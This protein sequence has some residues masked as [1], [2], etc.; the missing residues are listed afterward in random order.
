MSK[1][2]GYYENF[3]IYII[4]LHFFAIRYW[5]PFKQLFEHPKKLHFKPHRNIHWWDFNYHKQT[6]TNLF[7]IQ[8]LV[9]TQHETHSKFSIARYF[10]PQHLTNNT[11]HCQAHPIIRSAYFFLL[12]IKNEIMLHEI[13]IQSQIFIHECCNDSVYC[14]C[15]SWGLSKAWLPKAFY[16]SSLENDL[17][18]SRFCYARYFH[19]NSPRW[20]LFQKLSH[21]CM[22]FFTLFPLSI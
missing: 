1:K 13:W 12:Q 20:T 11:L 8:Q 18:S 19:I 15:H 17:K 10:S 2:P 21:F 4:S 5:Y 3:I 14:F 16:W 7:L 9:Y 6:S 22:N